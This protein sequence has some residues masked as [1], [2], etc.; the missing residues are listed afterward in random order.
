[1]L[2]FALLALSVLVAEGSNCI[3]KSKVS[4]VISP[5]LN[6]R[7]GHHVTLSADDLVG[8]ASLKHGKY[9]YYTIL[10]STILMGIVNIV[11]SFSEKAKS[12]VRYVL[13][14]PVYQCDC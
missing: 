3:P 1:M 4:A 9:Y 13:T 5:I 8:L 10:W 2:P 12:H 11:S 6:K 7:K 14:N